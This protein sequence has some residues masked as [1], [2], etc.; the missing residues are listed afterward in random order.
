MTPEEKLASMGIQLPD[1]P[2][3]VANYVPFKV[4]G[5]LVYVSG[6]LPS[7]GG[8]VVYKGIV[9]DTVTVEDARKAAR[10]CALNILAAAKAAAGNL[11]AVEVLRVEGFVAC[12]PSFTAQPSVING[13]SDFLVEVLGQPGKHSRFAVGVPSLPLGACVEVAAVLRVT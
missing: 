6:Q 3:P 8:K 11:S 10:L 9:G 13:A 12:A 5:G 4:S 7:E 1:V 2:A